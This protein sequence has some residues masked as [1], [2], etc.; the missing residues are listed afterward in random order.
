MAKTTLKRIH[1]EI[2]DLKKE[3]LG[4]ITLVPSPD[5]LFHWKATIPGPEGSVYE[6]GT[7]NVEISLAHDYPYVYDSSGKVQTIHRILSQILRT[8]NEFSYTVGAVLHFPARF[9]C[10]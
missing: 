1:R 8:K 3:D 6:G 7:F 2:A 4:S 5:D 10:S 9:F